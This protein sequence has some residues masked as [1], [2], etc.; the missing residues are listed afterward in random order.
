MDNVMT[1]AHIDRAE[2]FQFVAF[3][4]QAHLESNPSLNHMRLL[5][6]T[7]WERFFFGS[8]EVALLRPLPVAGLAGAMFCG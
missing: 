6:A 3:R 1:P 5:D 2:N 8:P 7:S 4:N